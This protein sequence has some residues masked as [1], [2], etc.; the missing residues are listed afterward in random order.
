MDGMDYLNSWQLGSSAEGGWCA[1]RHARSH[2]QHSSTTT[3]H[4]A[5]ARAVSMGSA[6]PFSA[7]THFDQSRSTSTAPPKRKRTT[8]CLGKDIAIGGWGWGV[9]RDSLMGSLPA[10]QPAGPTVANGSAVRRERE[11]RHL[12]PSTLCCCCCCSCS[13]CVLVESLAQ[14]ILSYVLPL[15]RV[16]TDEHFASWP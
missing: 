3:Q 11:F 14:G 9:L 2:E 1:C 15:R 6:K 7:P 13:C 8:K 12:H 4:P 5:H 16:E 10:L